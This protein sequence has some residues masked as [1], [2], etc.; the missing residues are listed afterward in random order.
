[1]IAHETAKNWGLP[2]LSQ[3]GLIISKNALPFAAA[4]TER[5]VPNFSPHPLSPAL[6]LVNSPTRRVITP[7]RKP[8]DSDSQAIENQARKEFA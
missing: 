4:W 5:A 8:R 2:T 6:R 1:M 7:W 3:G